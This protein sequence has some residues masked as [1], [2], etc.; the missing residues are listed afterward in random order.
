MLEE[1]GCV[2]L[3]YSGIILVDLGNFV[4]ID[5]KIAKTNYCFLTKHAKIKFYNR[6][7]SGFL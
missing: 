6:L 4:F 2:V 1:C 3:T 5:G 7:S